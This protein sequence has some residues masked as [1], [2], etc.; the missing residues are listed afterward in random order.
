M[1]WKDAYEFEYT[2]DPATHEM[3]SEMKQKVFVQKAALPRNS[4]KGDLER[5]KSKRRLSASYRNNLP[6]ESNQETPSNSESEKSWVLNSQKKLVSKS[7]DYTRKKK[8]VRS[9]LKVLP[10]SSPSSGSDHRGKKVGSSPRG[11]QRMEPSTEL[12]DFAAMQPPMVSSTPISHGRHNDLEM[13]DDTLPSHFLPNSS[14]A[15]ASKVQFPDVWVTY[16]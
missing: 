13:A 7:A 3:V 1:A 4:S 2:S 14:E 6:S 8:R 5:S 15:G 10:L 11:E 9:K 12:Y 16:L